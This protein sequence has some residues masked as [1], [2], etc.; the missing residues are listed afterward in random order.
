MFEEA[1]GGTV[2][3][4]G[5]CDG[6]VIIHTDKGNLILEPKG[7]CCSRSWIDSYDMEPGF[8]GSKLL[9]LDIGPVQHHDSGCLKIYFSTIKTE[10]ARMTI[11]Y[12]NS[13]NGYYGGWINF[14]WKEKES[15]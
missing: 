7:D 13:S 5:E 2:L 1:I 6:N 8:I 9:D 4:V 11:E 12:R 10:R 14:I 15:V 3:W